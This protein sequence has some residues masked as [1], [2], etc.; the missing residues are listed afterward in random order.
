M[1]SAGAS[2]L[3]VAYF[4]PLTYLIWSLR[5]G[6]VALDDPFRHPGL[7]WR[8]TSPPPTENFPELP[9]VEHEAYSFI[10]QQ[11]QRRLEEEELP[12]D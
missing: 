4:F 12:H 6:P 7:E 2:I 10:P 8:T 9:V 11:T 3:A 5:N 1:S